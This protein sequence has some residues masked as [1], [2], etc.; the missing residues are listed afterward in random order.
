MW[1]S[2]VEMSLVSRSSRSSSPTLDPRESPRD[3]ALALALA[4]LAKETAALEDLEKVDRA[5]AAFAGKREDVPLRA[6]AELAAR[7]GVTSPDDPDAPRKLAGAIGSGYARTARTHFQMEGTT[8]LPVIATAFGP[9]IPADATEARGLVHGDLPGRREIPAAEMAWVLGQDRALRYL[10]KDVESFPALPFAMRAARDGVAKATRDPGTSTDLY[11]AWLG[12]LT[13]LADKPAGVLPSFTET[14]AFADMRVA[15]TV[16]GYAQIR[17]NHVLLVPMTM[18]EGGCEI[19]D[20]WVDPAPAVYDALIAYADR[21]SRALR[22]VGEGAAEPFERLARTLRV[23]SRIARRE[24]AGEPLDDA[25]RRFLAMVVQEPGSHRMGYGPSSP[26][27]RGWYF[28]MFRA[29]EDAR[30]PARLVADHFGSV[31]TGQVDYAGVSGASMGLFVVDS[32]GAP[33]VMV[34]PVTRAFQA[35]GPMSPRWSDDDVPRIRRAEPWAASYVAPAAKAPPLVVTRKASEGDELVFEVTSE[36]D[37]GPVTLGLLDHHN[38]EVSAVTHEVRGAAGKRAAVT[39][40]FPD[41]HP[42]ADTATFGIEG[43]RVAAKGATLFDTHASYGLGYP[44]TR[45]RVSGGKLA[46]DDV[47]STGRRPTGPGRR[48]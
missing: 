12:A 13:R 5:W 1:L 43:L 41:P 37:A 7:A 11:T 14:D 20:G 26:L 15:S 24:L 22:D 40:T 42:T 2:R 36:V 29:P 3:V 39:F 6:L 47:Y 34:G 4:D 17:H 33:R 23:L 10:A 46:R 16:A 32:G 31:Q 9:R 45:W 38:V 28:Q 35:K 21:G 48:L 25:E 44:D 27:E 19:P 30:E 18:D 8:E